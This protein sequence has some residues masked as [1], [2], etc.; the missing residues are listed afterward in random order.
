MTYN[1]D[2]LIVPPWGGWD[3]SGPSLWLPPNSCKF[4]NGWLFNKGR[5]QHFP[6]IAPLT[7]PPD[8]EVIQG[9]DTFTDSLGYIH[10]GVLTKDHIYYLNQT[11]VYLLQGN[12]SASSNASFETTAFLNKLFYV[13]GVGFLNYLDGS[14]GVNVAGN[15]PGTSFFMGKLAGRLILL[16]LV[17]ANQVFPLNIRWCAVNNPLQWDS[18]VDPSAGS[19]TIPEVEDQIYG[20]ANQKGLGVIFRSSGI[21]IMVPTGT[22]APTFSLSSFE[23]GAN[24]IGV[25][26]PYTLDS[27]GSTSIFA[28]EDD[29][30][31]MANLSEPSAIGGKAKKQIYQDLAN[32]SSQPWATFIG[33]LTTGMDYLSYWLHIPQNNNNSSTWIYHLNTQTWVNQQIP[34]GIVKWMGDIAVA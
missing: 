24:G 25:K 1:R 28:S 29:I 26:F 17:E 5:M 4:M 30:Y 27:Y 23:N 7:N 31:M 19:T 9:A 10:T 16:N 20:F 8:G 2:S 34:F 32:A 18:T 3:E 22:S 21:T 11:N 13:N 33:K 14:Q 6:N 12:T 15:V